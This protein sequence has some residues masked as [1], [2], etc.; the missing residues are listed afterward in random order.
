MDQIKKRFEC[1][2]CSESR[3]E[4]RAG[5]TWVP[6]S[7]RTLRDLGETRQLVHHWQR[8]QKR[9]T[10]PGDGYFCRNCG[11]FFG[12]S[13]QEAEDCVNDRQ[14]RNQDEQSDLS[15]MTIRDF[16]AELRRRPNLCFA[17]VCI[18]DNG[19][20]NLAIESRGNPTEVVGILARGMK[21]VIEWADKDIKW[22]TPAD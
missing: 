4:Y 22:S 16:A 3:L 15:L 2:R 9:E 13:R 19:R 6:V 21:K 12:K 14:Q 8:Q 20:D 17:I 18:E 5:I 11:T 1:P 7:V 10:A